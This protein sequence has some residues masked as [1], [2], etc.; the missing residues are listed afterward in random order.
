MSLNKEE[1]KKRIRNKQASF[2]RAT[3]WIQ[4]ANERLNELSRLLLAINSIIF[5]LTIPI[6]WNNGSFTL[7]NKIILIGSW[8][9][10]L[11]SLVYGFIN[12]WNDSIYFKTLAKIENK[13]ESIWSQQKN[14]EK[15]KKEDKV[16]K[17]QYQE[18][19]SFTPFFSQVIFTIIAI[20]LL[21]ILGVSSLIN[22]QQV[23]NSF[24]S[25][26]TKEKYNT[27]YVYKTK[28]LNLCYYKK[29]N[30]KFH[31][32]NQPKSEGN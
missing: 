30:S 22:G 19:T 12:I 31:Q 17:E 32:R 6:A 10:A 15:M 23:N 7:L 3:I 14:Y 20:G 5:T 16:N 29:L 28:Q 26:K 25:W 13:S 18:S 21:F 8:T 27:E 9:S 4:N 1:E 11:I 24:T 2:E